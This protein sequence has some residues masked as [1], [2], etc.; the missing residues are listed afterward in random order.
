MSSNAFTQKKK[1]LN[2]DFKESDNAENFERKLS[3]VFTGH[4]LNMG[5]KNLFL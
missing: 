2:A 5:M 3:G 4:L 1:V